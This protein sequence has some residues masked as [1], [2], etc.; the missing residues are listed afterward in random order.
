MEGKT[1]IIISHRVSSVKH[2]DHIIV[3]DDGEIIEQGSHQE[4]IGQNG[5]YFDIHEQQQLES[6]KNID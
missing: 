5:V 6:I 4:L 1:T 3:L 2:C